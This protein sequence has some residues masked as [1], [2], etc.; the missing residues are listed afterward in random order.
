MSVI[1]KVKMGLRD[2]SVIKAVNTACYREGVNR[3]KISGNY[4]GMKYG[5]VNRRN[6]NSK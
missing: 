6:S 1:G 3:C 4:R 2:M 5:L